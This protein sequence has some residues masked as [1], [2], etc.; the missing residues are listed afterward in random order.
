MGRQIEILATYQD[1]YEILNCITKHSGISF[2]RV[3]RTNNTVEEVPL[4]A[5]PE[6]PRWSIYLTTLPLAS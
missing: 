2:I 6:R 3:I 5:P 4:D 1:V